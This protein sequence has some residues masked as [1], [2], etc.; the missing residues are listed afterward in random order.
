[1]LGQPPAQLLSTQL[2][3]N[4]VSV[5]LIVTFILQHISAP[6]AKLVDTTFV[7]LDASTRIH[8]VILSVGLTAT[9]A[10]PAIRNS[11]FLQLVLG[12]IGATGGGQLAGMLGIHQAQGWSLQ[13]PPC[14]RATHLVE[15]IDIVVA[16]ICSIFY[17]L[18]TLS[19]P[20]Y[21]PILA[22]VYGNEGKPLFSPLGARAACTLI[23]ALGFAYRAIV[24]HWLPA[25]TAIG[26]TKSGMQQKVNG[27]RK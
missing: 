11:L 22:Y 23:F 8:A 7:F 5:H 12:T 27:T 15:V 2:L 16:F 4:H 26:V 13:T 3:V 19:H 24:L 1:M 9:S 14:L 25:T 20:A 10:N 6:V 17:G 18:T 21:I